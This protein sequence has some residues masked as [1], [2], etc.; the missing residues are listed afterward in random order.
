MTQVVNKLLVLNSPEKHS[1]LPSA[2][3]RI[4]FKQNVQL[5]L[6]LQK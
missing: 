5:R 2:L 3:F 4:C 6:S 1:V